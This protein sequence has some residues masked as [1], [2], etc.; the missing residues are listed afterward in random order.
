[1][2]AAICIHRSQYLIILKDTFSTIRRVGPNYHLQFP[3]VHTLQPLAAR[4][5]HI[6]E[7]PGSMPS[8]ITFYV[9]PPADSRRGVSV[10]GLGGVNLPGKSGVR[11][12]D[13]TYMATA[14]YRR[15]KATQ[16]QQQQQQKK[17][18]CRLYLY[19]RCSL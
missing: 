4:L 9:S 16:Q 5:T 2:E 17:K 14:I 7:V 6:P 10:T 18:H 3:Q 11:F 8:P 12:T 13:R 19:E 1:M 15:R